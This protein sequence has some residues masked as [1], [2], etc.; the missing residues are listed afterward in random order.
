MVDVDTLGDE[1]RGP[2]IARKL[3]SSLIS[4]DG[5]D[6]DEGLRKRWGSRTGERMT[7]WLVELC[8]VFFFT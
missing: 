5:D 7:L 1:A 3:S 4:G 8:F 2:R 6:F